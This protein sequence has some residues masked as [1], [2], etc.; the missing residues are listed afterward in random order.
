[1]YDFYRIESIDFFPCLAQKYFPQVHEPKNMFGF[2][3]SFGVLWTRY[4]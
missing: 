4:F 2:I 3:L 1:M